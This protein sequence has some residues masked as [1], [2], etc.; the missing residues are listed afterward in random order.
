MPPH[1]PTDITRDE[2]IDWLIRLQ[3]ARC[4]EAD[5]RAFAA[6]LER[7]E[8]HR[9]AYAEVSAHMG[10]LD[11]FK[12]ADLPL[13]REAL[14]YRAPAWRRHAGRA[15]RAALAVAMLALGLTAFTPN[16]WLGTDAQ[17]ETAHGA[18]RSVDL[19]DGSRLELNTDTEVKVHLSHWSRSVELVRG[20]AYFSVAHDAARPFAV[21][22]GKGRSVDI[23]TEFEVFRQ[24]DRVL[25][26]VH[27][28]RVRVDAR[29]SRA[30]AAPQSL[31]YDAAGDF[32]DDDANLDIDNLTAW[33]RGR[34]VFDNRR[35][36]AVLAE[37]GRYSDTSIVL[38]DPALAPLKVS[39]SFFIDHL[40]RSLD[41]I[42]GNLGAAIRRP[43]PREVILGRP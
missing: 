3:S 33:R 2:A 9:S 37:I 6:W 1:E 21:T 43:N 27:Q 11:S 31:A 36:D 32:L 40:D 26:A 30:L 5:R 39:G 16:G 28:G 24:R 25:V 38:A 29:G 8:A 18:R 20:E 7:S 34:L 23:G 17:Y 35:L 12:G 13:R 14:R 4:S 41:V 10:W 15:A 19:A 42:A 22:A